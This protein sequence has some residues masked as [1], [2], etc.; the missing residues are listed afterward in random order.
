MDSESARVLRMV[1]TCLKAHKRHEAVTGYLRPVKPK[2]FPIWFFTDRCPLVIL[3]FSRCIFWTLIVGLNLPLA[4]LPVSCPWTCALLPSQVSVWGE[5][6]CF[7]HS[8][9][10]GDDI[11]N[12]SLTV[13]SPQ[14]FNLILFTLWHEHCRVLLSALAKW[15]LPDLLSCHKQLENWTKRVKQLFSDVQQQAART[16]EAWWLWLSCPEELSG[17]RHK[18]RGASTGPGCRSGKEGQGLKEKREHEEGRQGK[19]KKESS[20]TDRDKKI[21]REKSGRN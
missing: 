16:R 10:V 15:W 7:P 3:S 11:Q 2:I 8:P 9:P 4:P 14:N 13:S 19:Y 21:C 17:A 20:A 5:A 6:K 12:V 1:V 18:E